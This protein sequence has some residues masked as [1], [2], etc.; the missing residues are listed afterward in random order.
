MSE[1]VGA[2]LP[3]DLEQF[4]P[5]RMQRL[6]ALLA[7][8]FFAS[9]GDRGMLGWNEWYVLTALLREEGLTATDI[10]TRS[11]LGKTAIS[12]AVSA[13][14]EAGL[15]S[16]ER[17]PADRRVERLAISASGRLEQAD[18]ARRATAYAN[19]LLSLCGADDIRRMV[20]LLAAIEESL[21]A[22]RAI[23]L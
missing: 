17:D 9:A 1:A 21:V 15:I 23:G 19:R 6:T 16:R 22:S 20:A 8:D 5:Y 18:L 10:H 12:R 14:E 4:L 11:G 13:L 3:F 2:A 7:A